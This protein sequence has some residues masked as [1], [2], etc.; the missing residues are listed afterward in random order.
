[1][2]LSRLKLADSGFQLLDVLFQPAGERITLIVP[3]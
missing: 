3:P 2:N 1:M